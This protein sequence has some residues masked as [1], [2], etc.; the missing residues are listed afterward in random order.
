MASFRI[1]IGTPP[2]ITESG[3][4]ISINGIN[5]G[6][7]PTLSWNNEY[8]NN[9]DVDLPENNGTNTDVVIYFNIQPFNYINVKS[10]Y[11]SSVKLIIYN[12][13]PNWWLV[14]N[15]GTNPV[16]ISPQING[17]ATYETKND[18][19]LSANSHNFIAIVPGVPP[20][21]NALTNPTSFQMF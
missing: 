6:G 1:P 20:L 15:T 9:M 5:I 19:T 2:V 10:N 3:Q 18:K 13:P 12:V 4:S 21:T 16:T 17:A 7:S 11:A 8:N 14:H